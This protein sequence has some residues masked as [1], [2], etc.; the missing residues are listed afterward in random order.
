[1]PVIKYPIINYYHYPGVIGV[2]LALKLRW[3]GWSTILNHKR[4]MIKVLPLNFDLLHLL[5]MLTNHIYFWSCICIY[6]LIFSV[7][8]YSSW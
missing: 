7:L 4:T 5:M 8:H 1:M 6:L 2:E 3:I